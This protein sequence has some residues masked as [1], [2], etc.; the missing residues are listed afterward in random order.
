MIILLVLGFALLLYTL[1][2]FV[3]HRKISWVPFVIGVVLVAGNGYGLANADSKHLFMQE[4]KAT[5][6]ENIQPAGRVGEYNFI[7]TKDTEG[8]TRYT[9]MA[10]GKTFQTLVGNTTMK[11]K[12]GSPAK[13]E[14]SVNNYQTTNFFEQFMR[15]GEPAEIAMGTDYVMTVPSNWYFVTTEHYEELLKLAEK[16]GAESAKAMETKM[17]SEFEAATKKD[18][19]FADDQKAQDDLKKK[20]AD[21]EAKKAKDSLNEA[22][23]KQLAEWNK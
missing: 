23:K 2:Q 4:V 7:T 12:A 8:G 22:V 18:T 17:T 11:I 14:T 3:H 21:S 6:T 5:K 1:M 16:S 9:Y 20:I 19:G 13:L 10:D 15:W